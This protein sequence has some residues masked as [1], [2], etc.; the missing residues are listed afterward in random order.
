MSN[1]IDQL[2]RDPG[3]PADDPYT[4]HLIRLYRGDFERLSNLYST[5]RP[6]EVIRDLVRNHCDAVEAQQPREKRHA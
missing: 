5:K 2:I 4:K 1:P 6:N 3:P